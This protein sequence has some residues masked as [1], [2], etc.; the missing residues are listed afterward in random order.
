MTTKMTRYS[1]VAVLAS[2]E[3]IGGEALPTFTDKADLCIQDGCPNIVVDCETV[4]SV[5][6]NGLEFL[7]DLQDRCEDLLGAVKLCNLDDTL[8]TVF[9]ITRLQRRFEIFD[10]LDSAV[11]S[12][13]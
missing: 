12:F 2:N 3:E 6:S 5:D 9:R 4:P 7:L 8:K 1:S 10:D 13:G 11:R